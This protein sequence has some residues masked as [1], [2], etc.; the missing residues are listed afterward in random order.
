MAAST[1]QNEDVVLASFATLSILQLIK[2][3]QQKHGLRH[4]DYQRYRGYCARRVRRIRKS[5]KY[6]HVHKSVPKHPA[7]FTARKIIFDVVS[8]ERYLQVAVFDAERNWSYAMQLKQEA[9]EDVHSRKRFHMANKLRKAV[10]HTSNLESIVRMCDRADAATKLEAQAYNAWMTGYLYFELKQWKKALDFLKTAR[11]IYEKLA[12]VGKFRELVD[13][14][15]ARCREIQPQMRYSCEI[16][17]AGEKILVKNDEVKQLL[18]AV[19]QFDAQ[20]Q[21]T[22]SHEDKLALYERL[23]SG[24]RDTI[25]LWNDELKKS[26]GGL[27]SGGAGTPSDSD[28]SASQLISAYLDFI[29]LTKTIQRYMLIVSYTKSQTEKKVKPQDLLRLYDSIIESCSDILQLPALYD[30]AQQRCDAALKSVQSIKE[31]VYFEKNAEDELNDLS[32]QIVASKYM[33]QA[34]RLAEAAG[35][36][37]DEQSSGVV[38]TRSLYETLDEY[39][40]VSVDDL[41]RSESVNVVS[42][43]P[44]FIATPNK[45]MFFDLALNH[46]KMPDL[47]TKISSFGDDHSSKRSTPSK[48]PRKGVG[49]PNDNASLEGISGLVKG[50]FW[51]KK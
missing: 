51:G 2:D 13:L 41:L 40:T 36:G 35:Q 43:P 27:F 15:K 49:L 4:G 29:R 48:Q 23:L 32:K 24:V 16:G 30:R 28:A 14:Y 7:K 26:S 6:T 31:S 12:D 45:P 19:E 34:N 8:E 44:N 22:A 42:L 46:I 20:L 33:T 21:Q 5:L 38:D 37:N 11:R 39:R 1:E 50:W 18:Q 10:Q 3:A 25:Q 9:G 47:E 17:W